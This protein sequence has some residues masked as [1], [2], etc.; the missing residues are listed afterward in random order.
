MAAMSIKKLGGICLV[1]GAIAGAVP[2]ILSVFLGAT[3]TE[4][5]NIF[6]F[7]ADEAVKNGIATN[8]YALISIIGFA[9]VTFGI[10]TLR[11]I[12]QNDESDNALMRLGAY[13]FFL[14]SLGLII[15]WS[16]DNAIV[17]GEADFAKH[18]MTIEMAFFFPSGVLYWAGA[19][20][21][22]LTLAGNSYVN[23]LF[24]R[25]ICIFALIA[26]A[27]HIYTILSIDPNSVSTIMPLFV[28]TGIGNLIGPAFFI[29]IGIKMMK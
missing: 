25:G 29:S 17:W 28:L 14:G 2:L 18:L 3:P 21:V 16:L 20:L 22:A 27:L 15:G 5:V 23:S 24:A 19:G 8:A 11:D 7:F 9:L 4:G 6:K 13:L 10:F 1:V 26:C 12:L